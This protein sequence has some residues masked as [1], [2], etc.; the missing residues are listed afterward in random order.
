VREKDLLDFARI[1]EA[2]WVGNELGPARCCRE[3]DC[4]NTRI[5]I[6]LTRES[7]VTAGLADGGDAMSD[8]RAG[9]ST[10][11]YLVIAL[12][13]Q[14]VISGPAINQFEVKDLQ[15]SPGDFEFQSQNAWST[16][17]PRRRSADVAPGEKAFD[18]NTV[19][20][21]REALEI[22]LGVTDW[23]R[24]RLGIEFE[25]ERLDDPGSFADADRFA[26]LKFDEV[27]VEGVV[28][29]I[30]PKEEGIGLGLLM[31]Y[32]SPVGDMEAAAEFYV[33]PIVEA[34]TGPWSFIANLMFVKF[35]GGKA[36]PGDE[37]FVRDEKWDFSY[38]TQLEYEVSRNWGVALE[39]YGTFDRL[40]DTGTPGENRALFGD[41]DQHRAGAVV[42]Y[43]F[44]PDENR[45]LS[46]LA[47][48]GSGAVSLS[49]DAGE[50]EKELSVAIGTGV[51]FGL[52]E[53][54]PDLTY[55]LSVEVEY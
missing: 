38:A 23:F 7:G 22:Q 39:A 17:Q 36:E 2:W 54:T 42:Y 19:I 24:V 43:T 30:K 47:K 50:D 21:Q 16:G 9:L 45:A 53:N 52:N 55:K 34:H 27:A 15:S 13:P 26:P 44:F 12:L 41:F 37:D 25:Q 14:P 40:G 8:R 5:L 11:L 51:L 4:A 29:F 1:K 48:G 18:D 20:K 31:E 32:G 49:N 3:K 35:M 10:C 46:H 6:G 33:G 28:V